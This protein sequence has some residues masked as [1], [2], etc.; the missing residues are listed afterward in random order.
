MFLGLKPRSDAKGVKFD[1]TLYKEGIFYGES[2][3]VRR[4]NHRVGSDIKR[5]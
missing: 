2:A 1:A 4:E 3:L 5:G